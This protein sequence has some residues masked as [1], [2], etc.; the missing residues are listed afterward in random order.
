MSQGTEG[1]NPSL[2]AS[3]LVNQQSRLK[4]SVLIVGQG[5]A[6]TLL[7]WELERVGV[8]FS[9]VDAGHV[10]AATKVAAGIINPITGRR[11]VKSEGFETLRPVARECYRGIE[12]RLGE[13][14]WREMRVRRWFAEERE[15]E[16]FAEKNA[17]GALAPFAESA[18]ADGF[19]MGRAARVELGKL[20]GLSRKRWRER[21][22]LQEGRME[23]WE[24]TAGD[25]VMIDCRGAEAEGADTVDWRYSK[26]ECVELRMAGLDPGVVWNRRH[27]LVATGDGL[28]K[29]GATNEPGR[30]DFA[31]T[32][33]ARKE[34]ERS[35]NAM[36]FSEFEI[37][38]QTVGVRVY[39]PDKR[40]VIGWISREARRGIF[41]GLGAKGALY[42]PALARAWAELLRDG[43]ELPAA[44][45]VARFRRAS[46]AG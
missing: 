44:W 2:S 11:L 14:L 25:G 27:W 17:S 36:G 20:I 33:E 22:I 9:I 29:A 13:T 12:R 45:D 16:V 39:S 19:W 46:A 37:V 41:C 43:T 28:A 4:A 21:G 34:L 5:L 26:G 23:K 7:A 8:A 38:G 6:G 10:R 32:D 15:R 3:F 31:V 35:V 18:D 1:S 42:A 30:R 40:P 24:A